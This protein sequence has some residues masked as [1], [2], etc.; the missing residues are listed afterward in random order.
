MWTKLLIA[1]G[2]GPQEEGIHGPPKQGL[3]GSRA[4]SVTFVYLAS[5][6]LQRN[7]VLL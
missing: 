7:I 2:Q 1:G 5:H 6:M 3:Q 4:T